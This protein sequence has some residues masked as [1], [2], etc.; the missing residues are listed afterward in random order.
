MRAVAIH[1]LQKNKQCPLID[2]GCILNSRNIYANLQGVTSPH[3]LSYDTQ[4]SASWRP[5]FLES[6]GESTEWCT[7][8]ACICNPGAPQ[9]LRPTR[10]ISVQEAQLQYEVPNIFRAEEIQAELTV[11]IKKSV[12]RWRMTKADQYA[13]TSF[14]VD[15]SRRL[16]NLLPTLEALHESG[17]LGETTLQ[18]HKGD[19]LGISNMWEIDAM[20]FNM[21]YA[22][23]TKIVERLRT[24]NVHH[25]L[26]RN[27]QFIAAVYVHPIVHNVFSVW[28]YYGSVYP[29]RIA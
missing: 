6:S 15:I 25:V 13:H 21:P 11:E 10:F 12:R 9:I 26:H 18:S 22:N 16:Q 27:V 20:A 29:K 8:C 24:I 28:I 7:V 1:F 5:F 14:N 23:Y 19:V 2:I 3:L 4:D 17:R